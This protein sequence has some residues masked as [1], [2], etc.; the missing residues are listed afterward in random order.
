MKDENKLSNILLVED[1]PNDIFLIK[2]AF[3]KTDIQ[4]HLNTAI[5]GEEAINYIKKLKPKDEFPDLIL[6][7]INLPKVTGLEVLKF[8]KQNKPTSGIPTVVF[9]SSDLKSD[10]EYSYLN[11]ADLYIHKPN[12]INSF[13][14]TM[15][16]IKN[17]F[18]F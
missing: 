1:N 2:I 3:E 14:E 5:N 13:K 4:A 10:M 8:I 7:D 16:Y 12:N 9:T 17:H 15:I 11:K 18:C 6:L